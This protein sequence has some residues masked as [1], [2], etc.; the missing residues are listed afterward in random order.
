[1]SAPCSRTSPS[2]S[3]A[4]WS[5]S[6]LASDGDSLGS[7]ADAGLPGLDASAGRAERGR[8]APE[9]GGEMAGSEL[10]V[11]EATRRLG[12][13]DAAEL[14]LRHAA[15]IGAELV[16]D[17]EVRRAGV[18][19]LER[20]RGAS[21]TAV[22]ALR[23]ARLF[24]AVRCF[25]GHVAKSLRD[26]FS[27]PPAERANDRVHCERNVLGGAERRDIGSRLAQPLRLAAEECRSAR[28]NTKCAERRPGRVRPPGRSHE[29][30]DRLAASSRELL[31]VVGGLRVGLD[32]PGEQID[33]A[34]PSFGEGP[35]T[36]RFLLADRRRGDGDRL[37]LAPRRRTEPV[38][39]LGLD[40]ERYGQKHAA[41]EGIALVDRLG[42][43]SHRRLPIEL[44]DDPALLL[45]ARTQHEVDLA[46]TVVVAH[47]VTEL[48]PFE[49]LQRNRSRRSLEHDG[50][51]KVG[52]RPEADGPRIQ[53]EHVAETRGDAQLGIGRQRPPRH[54]PERR[55][56]HERDLL[57]PVGQHQAAARANGFAA[58]HDGAPLGFEARSARIDPPVQAPEVGGRLRDDGKTLE[59]RHVERG[60]SAPR[61]R[62][63]R[64]LRRPA[65]VTRQTPP[66][67]RK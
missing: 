7:A 22:P 2:S 18:E 50:G 43:L 19:Q 56:L 13:D 45:A 14:P 39:V 63:R 15:E 64:A 62:A 29:E 41:Q 66:C 36:S 16:E 47:A 20:R 52:R 26:G 44:F 40:G 9:P 37:T 48:E 27:V 12:S 42:A 60:N 65:P 49:A 58:N 55:I 51:R 54:H 30:C 57:L 61:E 53:D 5:K 28:R 23:L 3:S 32:Q 17:Q 6:W 34:A 46:E 67:P 33:D 8:G 4:T 59:P 21:V 10:G 31:C 11:Q 38:R 1:M 35:V 24:E 25:F